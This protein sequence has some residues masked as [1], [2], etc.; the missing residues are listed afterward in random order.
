M[1]LYTT[2]ILSLV[3]NVVFV[4]ESGALSQKIDTTQI[5]KLKLKRLDSLINVT[6]SN[7]QLKRM[8][9]YYDEYIDLAIK[10]QQHQEAI[11]KGIKVIYYVNNYFGQRKKAFKIIEKLEK[12]KHHV[13]DSFLLGSI[14]LKKGG[15]FFNGKNYNKA[16]DN[17]S[18]AINTFT[19]K[20]S[21]HTADALFFRGQAYYNINNFY[22]ALSSF[23]HALDYYTNLGD[24]A[25]TFYTKSSIINIHGVNNLI[26]KTIKERQKL[27][28]EKIKQSFTQGLSNDYLNLA[29]DYKNNKQFDQQEF[30]L[31]KAVSIAENEKDEFHNLSFIYCDIAQYYLEI[32]NFSKATFYFQ[33]AQDNVKSNENDNF[34]YFQKLKSFYLF[35]TGALA[36]ALILAENNLKEAIQQNYTQNII[37][38]NK[39]LYKIHKAQNNLP[40]ALNYYTSYNKIK[41]SLFNREKL[42]ILYYYQTQ[43]ETKLKEQKIIEQKADINNLKKD[44]KNKQLLFL[45]LSLS[46]IFIIVLIYFFLN[47]LYLKRKQKLQN[48]YSQNLLSFLDNERKRVSKDMHDS[49][50]HKL[51]LVKNQVLLNKDQK[52]CKLI[53]DAIN[54]IRVISRNLQPLQIK[55]IGITKSIHTLI[56]EMDKHYK[57]T[58]IFGDIDNIDDLLSSKKEMN[59]YRI[60]QECLNNIIKHSKA[61]SGKV[62]IINNHKKILLTVEDNGVGFDYCDRYKDYKSLGLK[63]IKNRV[64]FLQGNLKISSKI[65]KGTK[66]EISIPKI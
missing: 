51:L 42:N 20:D 35:K 9:G 64:N 29:K 33:K 60:I 22:K 44:K 21:I 11:N 25:Y 14:Y 12:I 23:E 28:D 15:I 47:H 7:N 2:F 54:E 43:H 46:S 13:N 53:D 31:K 49:L 4:Q 50:G 59:I 32:D 66:I 52:S 27:I 38:A 30:Y 37:D 65:Y 6:K 10:S 39:L 41:D 40:K 26:E 63:N 17:Y 58:L 62:S 24:T 48:S 8:V 56:D 57:K 18:L 3:F 1:K 61:D 55:Q 19:H 34:Y 5:N 16:I 45:V 36:E